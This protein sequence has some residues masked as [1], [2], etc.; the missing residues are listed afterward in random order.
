GAGGNPKVAN[1]I[2]A[3]PFVKHPLVALSDSD[4]FLDRGALRQVVRGFADPR[5]GVVTCLYR[6]AVR[7]GASWLERLGALHINAWFIPAA[8]VACGLAPM[9]SAWGQLSVIRRDVLEAAGGFSA[10]ARQVAD[11]HELGQM[12]VRQGLRVELADTVVTTLGGE[13]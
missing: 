2:G 9:R 5:V 3:E 6:G 4:V 1:L 7:Q 11:D 8:L 13:R 12:A 10:L